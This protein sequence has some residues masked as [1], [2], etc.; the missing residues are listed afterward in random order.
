MLF[1]NPTDGRRS[2]TNIAANGKVSQTFR[3]CLPQNHFFGIT[4]Q[5]AALA[6]YP[7]NIFHNSK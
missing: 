7:Q 1:T 3:G 5:V 6:V 4:K 2:A